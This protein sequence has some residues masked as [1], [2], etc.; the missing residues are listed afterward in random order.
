MELEGYEADDLIATL[1]HWA[2]ARG[3]KIVVVSGD[4]DLHQLIRDPEVRQWDP[5]NDRVF[6]ES[7][8]LE[9]FG[10]APGQMVDYLALVGDTTDNIP[11]VKGV[12][13]KTA[14]QLLKKWGSLDG[15]YAHLNE[16]SP[17][18]LRQKLSA[19][20]PS[21]YLSRELVSLRLDVLIDK[22]VGGV[23][24]CAAHAAGNVQVSVKNSSS[25]R[26]SICSSGE[27]AEPEEVKLIS[28]G[29]SSRKRAD[30]IIRTREEL[31]EMVRIAETKSLIAIEIE[32]TSQNAMDADLVSI[33]LCWDDSGAWYIPVG[34]HAR[35]RHP[36]DGG[37]S[38]S[39]A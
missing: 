31:A 8:V 20:N 4:K 16:I 7:V 22:G 14:S 32:T 6:T 1:T 26:F 13:E 2:S 30:R 27:W 17:D 38:A 35:M 36:N 3:L 19:G 28:P 34:H 23:C 39:R 15:I 29:P 9:R 18:S 5:Q 24:A 10:V 12:G 37:R 21:A 11:G 25:K 33:A